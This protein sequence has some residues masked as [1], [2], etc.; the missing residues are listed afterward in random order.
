MYSCTTPN[1][2]V[3]PRGS[4]SDDVDP[5]IEMTALKEEHELNKFL[6]KLNN[7]HGQQQMNYAYNY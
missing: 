5:I 3:S 2:R 1:K 7:S 4:V 6:K